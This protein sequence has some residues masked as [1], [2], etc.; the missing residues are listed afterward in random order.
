MH[1][2][3]K[4]LEAELCGSLTGL[5]A[6]QTLR[7]PSGHPEK[8]C[9]Q[10]IVGHLLLGYRSTAEAFQTRVERGRP[11]R[12]RA[13]RRQRLGQMCVIRFGFFPSGRLAPESLLPGEPVECRGGEDL[14]DCV[15][16]ELARLN[17]AAEV[18]RALF[19]DVAAISHG[20][21]GPMSVDH[22]RGFHLVHGRHHI[23]QILA[24]RKQQGC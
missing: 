16:A 15:Q 17:Q 6:A 8:W 7:G 12:A 14:I 2:T 3:L 23:R 11:T 4:C 20:V 9:V 5:T 19:G 21:L 13:N 22:W 24:L 18:A 10:Q 1:P